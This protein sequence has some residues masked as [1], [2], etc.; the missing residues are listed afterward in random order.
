M[1]NIGEEICGEFLNL[2]RMNKTSPVLVFI[3]TL[4]YSNI[5][6]VL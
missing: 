5:L 2:I 3:Y 1:Q 4:G 6:N